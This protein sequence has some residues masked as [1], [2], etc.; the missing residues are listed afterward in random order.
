MKNGHNE[1]HTNL[2]KELYCM[3]S[4]TVSNSSGSIV[5]TCIKSTLLCRKTLSSDDHD[6][7]Q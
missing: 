1:K 3:V 7:Q 5:S 6:S 2:V 4:E